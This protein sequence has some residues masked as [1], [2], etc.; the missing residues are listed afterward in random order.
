M[1]DALRDLNYAKEIL[2]NKPIEEGTYIDIKPVRNEG[3]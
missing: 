2:G 1:K 3:V